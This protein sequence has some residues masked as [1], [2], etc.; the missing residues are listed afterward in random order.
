MESQHPLMEQKHELQEQEHGLMEH[1][2]DGMLSQYPIVAQELVMQF[3][4][5]VFESLFIMLKHS[6][7]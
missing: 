7:L 3:L 6:L 1:S 5:P 2:R 4:H